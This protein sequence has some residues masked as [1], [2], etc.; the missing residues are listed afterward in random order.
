M[1]ILRKY[2]PFRYFFL[3]QLN[4]LL[5]NMKSQF[6][7]NKL[8]ILLRCFCPTFFQLLYLRFS[9]TVNNKIVELLKKYKVYFL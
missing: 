6:H 2:K 1:F 5:E 3:K 7:N 9:T 8:F 4:I